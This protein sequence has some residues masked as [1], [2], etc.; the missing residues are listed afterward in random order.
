MKPVETEMGNTN[1]ST[2][3]RL[4]AAAVAMLSLGLM[5]TGGCSSQKLVDAF[6]Q[7]VPGNTTVG[8][9]A[10]FTMY[11]SASPSGVTWAITK[12]TGCTGNACGTL[13][14]ATDTS[15]V[16]S[17][18]VS[19]SG[20][21][22]SVTITATS[23][24]D[25]SISASQTLTVYPVSVQLTGPSNTTVIPLTT[26]LFNASV[27]GDLSNSGVTW[28]VTGS[29]CAGSTE[30]CGSFRG[31]TP[32][33]A[34]YLAP[35]APQF[36][37]V[38]VTATSIYAP[39]ESASITLG[40]PKLAIY[41][42]TPTVLPAAIAGQPYSATIQ[43]VGNTPPYTFSYANLP[44]WITPTAGPQSIT[45][46]GTP[47]AGTQGSAYPTITV[48]DSETPIPTVSGQPFALTTY[49]AAPTGNN[50]LTGSYAF[51]ATGWTDGT[52]VQTT[53]NGIEYIGSFTADGNGN[54]TGGE[55]DINDPNT[56]I[57]SY[58]TL[59]GTYD[60]Q[61]GVDGS[62]NPVPG[63]QT[64]YITL[65]PPGKPPFPITLA[66]S[67]SSL[68]NGVATQGHF[69]EFDDTTGIGA[70]VT[71]NSSGIRA[72]G[73]MALQ[74][75]GVLNTGNKSPFTG[76]YAF[77]MAGYSA[78]SDTTV[79]CYGVHTCGP[80]SLAGSMVFGD[81]GAI[82]SGIEDVTVAENNGSSIALSGSVASAGNTD[83]SG[84]TTASI[85]AA[86]N[87]N[88]PDWPSNFAIYAVNPQNF[89]FMS[90]DP[91]S[92]NTLI[93]G[94]AQQQNLADIASNP[95][96]STLPLLL[97][98]NVTST[99]SF[100]TKGPNGQIRVEVQL[101]QP[102]PTSATAGK[103]S[104]FQWVN[105]SGTY[106]ANGGQ[107]GAVGAF[108]YTVAPATGRVTT[109]T[110]A[111]P[112]LYLVDT[113]QG[114]GT[115]YSTANNTAAGLF[116]FQPQ[117]ATALNPGFYSYYVYNGTS[118]VAPMET[119][120]LQIPSGGVPSNGTTVTIPSGTDYTSFGT[121]ANVYQ[122]GE[123]ILFTG[124]ITGTLTESAGMFNQKQII[125]PGL[126][127]GCGQQTPQGAG[128]VIS[129][130]SFVCA[131]GGGSFAGVHLF[132]Q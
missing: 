34:T 4:T 128:W 2:K 108:N 121:L 129:P 92:T 64:G 85:M 120:I 60:L 72:Q 86:A 80:I 130:T 1:V 31:A 71:V 115:Q 19:I 10:T 15:V 96:S 68:Q 43:I 42:Y 93:G 62:G 48:T 21:T 127:Q 77:G 122:A 125:L 22:M 87:A 14:G 28:T 132:Q 113:N 74:S 27:P 70:N 29:S 58:A 61:Y 82:S 47:P 52:S 111:E 37:N 18:P 40:I 100:S 73:S 67:L 66:V 98:G 94:R 7:I 119:G 17:A 33:Q 45:L 104:G 44:S 78:V 5:L 83:A 97:Y 38:T 20:S 49:P 3:S 24:T 109:S 84:R 81:A 110:T 56:G 99:T 12:A 116:E 55:L 89:Y 123:P 65:V 118:Q 107:P 114:F 95:F 88:M 131:P 9:G 69:V 90:I 46:T 36:E 126:M 124:P 76:S 112:Y 50:L 35:P 101:L 25:S 117:T 59:G 103:L 91:Y 102:A 39:G 11:T 53:Y 105:A 79:T 106:T 8:T 63:Y 30:G 75:T 23:K 57:T 41:V 51:F 32:T 16:Y 13:S 54:I 26:A 6:V